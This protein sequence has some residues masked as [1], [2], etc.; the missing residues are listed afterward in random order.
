[1]LLA[2]EPGLFAQEVIGLLQDA[3]RR[4]ELGQAGFEFAA[5]HYDWSAIVP[6]LEAA[7]DAR[8]A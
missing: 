4:N 1:V 8:R 3:N 7:I 5:A 2:D 6:L